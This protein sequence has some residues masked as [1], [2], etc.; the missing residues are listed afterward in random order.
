VLSALVLCGALALLTAGLAGSEQVLDALRRDAGGAY[1]NRSDADLDGQLAGLGAVLSLWCVAA[2]GC[3]VLV[4]RR[5]NVA[6][7]PHLKSLR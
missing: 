2:I 1:D 4:L 7:V 6:G 3:A 5:S